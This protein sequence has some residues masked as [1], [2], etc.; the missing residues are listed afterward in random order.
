MALLAALILA[1]GTLIPLWVSALLIGA[2]VTG[3]GGA[4]AASGIR[5]FKGIEVLRAKQFKRFRRT[6]DG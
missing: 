3:I 4:L 6:S 1:L 5:A 2:M